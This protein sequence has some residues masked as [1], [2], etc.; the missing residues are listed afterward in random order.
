MKSRCLSRKTGL[1]SCRGGGRDDE[2]VNFL[3]LDDR[4]L[5]RRGGWT[6]RVGGLE[7]GGARPSRGSDQKQRRERVKKH[8]SVGFG[9]VVVDEEGGVDPGPWCR[10]WDDP[11]RETE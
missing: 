4:R 5:R 11:E 7:R 3:D 6:R 10:M 1:A 9:D 8:G 2:V